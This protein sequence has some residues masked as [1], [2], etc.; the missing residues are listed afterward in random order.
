MY[1]AYLTLSMNLYPVYADDCGLITMFIPLDYLFSY[2]CFILFSLPDCLLVRQLVRSG[3]PPL[4][5]YGTI[6]CSYISE[7]VHA[8]VFL[9]TL[10]YLKAATILSYLMLNQTAVLLADGSIGESLLNSEIKIALLCAQ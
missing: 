6:A 1:R 8:A 9:S 3:T 5:D 10:A 4:Y 7:Q 2:L